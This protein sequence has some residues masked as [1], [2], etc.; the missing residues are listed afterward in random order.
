MGGWT[1][2]YKRFTFTITDWG[3]DSVRDSS[4]KSKSKSTR[5]KLRCR[6]NLETFLHRNESKGHRCTSL[7]VVHSYFNTVYMSL[8]LIHYHGTMREKKMCRIF[9]RYSGDIRDTFLHLPWLLTLGRSDVPGD[10]PPWS[11]TKVS[12]TLHQRDPV[13]HL[14]PILSLQDG[15]IIIDFTGIQ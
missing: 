8:F 10:N 6:M 3:I 1:E 14:K 12:P 13:L 5:S 9:L 11:V 4:E 7:T 15:L 2:Q